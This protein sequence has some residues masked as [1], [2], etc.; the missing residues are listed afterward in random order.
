LTLVPIGKEA[1]VFFV[2][3][4][5]PVGGLSTAQIQDIYSGKITNWRRSAE[6]TKR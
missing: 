5:N 4:R 6:K 1:F 2:N 3:S